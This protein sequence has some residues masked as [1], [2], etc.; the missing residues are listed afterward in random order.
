MSENAMYSLGLVVPLLTLGNILRIDSSL[1][2]IDVAWKIAK[3]TI[4]IGRRQTND[5]DR[6]GLAN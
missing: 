1:R 3:N 6:N 2:K 4:D 5:S